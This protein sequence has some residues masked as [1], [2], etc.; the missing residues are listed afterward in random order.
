MK[1]AILGTIGT[2]NNYGGIEQCVEKISTYFVQRGLDVTI[3][4]TGNNKYKKKLK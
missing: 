4:N 1:I 3:C 2:T